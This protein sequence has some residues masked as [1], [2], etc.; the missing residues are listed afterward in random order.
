MSI[1]TV[2]RN[3]AGGVGSAVQRASKAMDA[4]FVDRP[5][6]STPPSTPPP[7]SANPSPAPTQPAGGEPAPGATDPHIPVGPQAGHPAD[8]D[9]DGVVTPAERRA[10]EV[11]GHSLSPM[12]QGGRSGFSLPDIENPSTPDGKPNPF[13]IPK[14]IKDKSGKDV[15]NPDYTDA[16]QVHRA[17]EELDRIHTENNPHID[18]AKEYADILAEQKRNAEVPRRGNA[19]SA[20]AIALGGGSQALQNY[21]ET[22]READM[23]DAQKRDAQLQF[24]KQLVDAHVKQLTD[25]GK[26][27]E[28]L[29]ANEVSMNLDRLLSESSERRKHEFRMQENEQLMGGRA[30]VA[31]IT[32][33]GRI[34][35]VQTRLDGIAHQTGLQ[36]DFYKA[37]SK[38][39]AKRVAQLTTGL[40]NDPESGIDAIPDILAAGEEIAQR[41]HEQ[42]V[43]AGG[44]GGTGGNT[45]GTG[46]SGGGGKMVQ[47]YKAGQPFG[48]P[49]PLAEFNQ[50]GGSAAA[51][52]H[53]Y[54]FKLQ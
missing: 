5:A 19:L 35:A 41:L 34:R 50:R 4:P 32:A 40:T 30:N 54:T 36:G 16:A 13:Y 7:T 45:G 15:P 23:T 44:S 14:T 24:K 6:P 33:N 9:G 47:M 2:I 21:Q 3:V 48:N 28:A 20:F 39:M 51:K 11:A 26:W 43:A 10:W 8:A 52:K 29:R 46:G 42:Q 53:G 25:E 27:K 1:G 49:I 38:E 17:M 22:N 18:Y 12:T 31:S 37:F